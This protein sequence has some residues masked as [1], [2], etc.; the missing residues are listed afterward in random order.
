MRS[1]QLSYPASNAGAKV[2]LFFGLTKFSGIFLQIILK[3]Y[4]FTPIY[5]DNEVF[6]YVPHAAFA[7]DG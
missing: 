7:Q 6:A 2:L 4:I 1:N 3:K 5:L